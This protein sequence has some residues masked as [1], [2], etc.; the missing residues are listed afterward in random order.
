MLSRAAASDVGARRARRALAAAPA[1]A[2]QGDHVLQQ[3][4][5]HK[6]IFI[7]FPIQTTLLIRREVEARDRLLRRAAAA[8]PRTK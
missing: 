6:A 8:P 3:F 1:A 5:A 7:E 4:A 2:A